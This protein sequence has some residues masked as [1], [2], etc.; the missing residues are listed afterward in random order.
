MESIL[1]LIK[2]Y[3]SLKKVLIRLIGRYI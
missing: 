2:E 1:D 3:D